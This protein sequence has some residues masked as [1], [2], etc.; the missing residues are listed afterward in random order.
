VQR[1]LAIIER[2]LRRFRRSP[3]LIVMSLVLP[4]VQLVILGYAFGGKVKHL[5]VGLVDQDHGVPAVR[6]RELSNAIAANAGTYELVPYSDPGQA[7]VALRNGRLNGVLTIPPGFSRRQLAGE[8]PQ[9]ALIEDNTDN[10][11]SATLA[12]TVSSLLQAY[13]EHVPSSRRIA[14][15]PTLELVEVYPY[16]PYIQY[17]LPGSI[18]M[19]IFMMVMIGGGIIYMDDKARGLH[20]GYLVTPISR[21]ELILGFN[22]SGA[23]K[24]V[25][26]GLV[27]MTV[28]SLIAGVPDAFA[29]LK[30][31]RMF[32]VITTTAVALVSMMFLLVVRMNDPLMPRAIFG[33]LNTV[34]YFPSGAVYPQQAFPGWM[35]G[36]ATVDPFTYAVHALKSLLLKDT[37][38]AAIS[39][40]LTFLLVFSAVTMAAATLLFKREL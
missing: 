23:I 10:F 25:I 18:V 7:L 26:A 5:R 29:P 36:I 39:L 24:A 1:V 8:A 40:D 20:E 2:E 15:D 4:I 38:F 21:F 12:S 31:L 3:M 19:S 22:I 11:V 16:V 28:G 34:L 30:L 9:I 35:R 27:L 6:L 14:S 13:N 32:V 37:G 33:V 17:L